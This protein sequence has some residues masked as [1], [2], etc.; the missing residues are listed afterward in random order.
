MA[1]KAGQGKEEE[2]SR[3][4]QQEEKRVESAV[5]SVDDRDQSAVD[6]VD[7]RD[8][9]QELLTG[10]FQTRSIIG[11][12]SIIFSRSMLDSSGWRYPGIFLIHF[13]MYTDVLVQV[14]F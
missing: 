9:T 2:E 14:M 10:G 4:R 6:S 8:H 7:G 5:D 12:A 3:A 11:T 13:G 1:R